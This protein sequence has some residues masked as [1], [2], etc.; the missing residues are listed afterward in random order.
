[1]ADLGGIVEEL[2]VP[3]LLCNAYQLTPAKI[4][5]RMREDHDLGHEDHKGPMGQT[6]TRRKRC[7]ELRPRLS[8]HSGVFDLRSSDLGSVGTLVDP[9][10]SLSPPQ[11]GK[12]WMKVRYRVPDS[13]RTGG[14]SFVPNR[15][16]TESAPQQYAGP[17]TRSEEQR[18]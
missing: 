3:S 7:V 9:R 1:M 14:I 18:S 11:R 6:S 8:V 13:T 2:L 5:S 4:Y 16:F 12:K 15:N 17:V 10:V